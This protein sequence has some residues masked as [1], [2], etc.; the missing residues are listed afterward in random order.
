LTGITVGAFFDKA[1]S[2]IFN[3]DND[4]IV[5]SYLELGKK[6]TTDLITNSL[7]YQFPADPGTALK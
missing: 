4:T 7:N 1:I 3:P 2:P 6:V 5:K